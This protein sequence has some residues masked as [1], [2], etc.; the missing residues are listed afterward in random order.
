[1]EKVKFFVK[2]GKAKNASVKD[3]RWALFNALKALG[4]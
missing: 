2:E 4:N 1:M 3:L